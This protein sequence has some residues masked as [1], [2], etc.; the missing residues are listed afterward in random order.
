MKK[1]ITYRKGD[2]V[3]Y[4]SGQG[5]LYTATVQRAHRDGSVTV[6][7]GFPI[8]DGRVVGGHQGDRF[9]VDPRRHIKKHIRYWAG[10]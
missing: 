1:D 9:R 5:F 3:E 6:Q 4:I 8:R 10:G 7:L 2:A